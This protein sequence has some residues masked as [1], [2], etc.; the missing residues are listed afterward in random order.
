MTNAERVVYMQIYRKEHRERINTT[1][2]EWRQ[3]HPERNREINR[4]AAAKHRM[5]VAREYWAN[6]EVGE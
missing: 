1:R 6:E 5:K 2:Q 3:T 4:R